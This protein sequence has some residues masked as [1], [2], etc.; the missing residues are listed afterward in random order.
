MNQLSIIS[1]VF[2]YVVSVYNDTE[3]LLPTLHEIIKYETFTLIQCA[4]DAT[5]TQNNLIKGNIKYISMVFL[6]Q[7][8]CLVSNINIHV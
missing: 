3:R 7:I 6:L 5:S 1:M 2:Q 4:L 8:L